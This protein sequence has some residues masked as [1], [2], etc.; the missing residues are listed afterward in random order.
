MPHLFISLLQALWMQVFALS[1]CAILCNSA[2]L[3]TN[4]FSWFKSVLCILCYLNDFSYGFHTF[5]HVHYQIVHLTRSNVFVG[6]PIWLFSSDCVLPSANNY[7][8]DS[9]LT[10][11]SILH[12]HYPWMFHLKNCI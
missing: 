6:S 3:Y 10:T 9:I 2:V 4:S 7:A 1:K 8:L 11:Y 12:D 5:I